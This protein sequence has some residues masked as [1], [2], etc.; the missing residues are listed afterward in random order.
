VGLYLLASTDPGSSHTPTWWMGN[1]GS[2]A[3]TPNPSTPEHGCNGLTGT[4]ISSSSYTDLSKIP[5]K[6]MYGNSMNTS[7]YTH[8]HIVSGSVT[9]IYNGTALNQT[10]AVDGYNWGLAIWNSVDNAANNLRNDSN[11]TSRAG[12]TQSMPLTIHVIAYTGNGGVDDG[13]LKRVAN[14]TDSSSFN[15]AQQ[16]GLYVPA[17]DAAAL[18]AAFNQVASS[19]LHLSR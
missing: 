6:D 11:F 15:S 5:S 8:S 12:D 16:Q 7:G 18:A 13:L 19:L 4:N 17:G 10:Q 2:D 9:S 1:G 14:T 3:A